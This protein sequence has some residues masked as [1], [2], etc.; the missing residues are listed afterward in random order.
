MAGNRAAQDVV[1]VGKKPAMSYVLAVVTQFTEG[2]RTVT[3]KARGMTIS[4]AVDVAEVVRNKFIQ[5][6]K[7]SGISIGTEEL[8][9]KNNEKVHVST[10]EITLMKV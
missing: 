3:L 4:K 10:I 6:A 1:F 8:A 9:D 2:Q 7:V 5:D